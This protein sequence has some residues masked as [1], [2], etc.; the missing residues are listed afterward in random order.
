MVDRFGALPAPERLLEVARLRIA[1]ESAGIASLAREGHELIVRFSADWSRSAAMRAMAPTSI[2]DR[3]PHVAVG[4]IT[5]GSN[6]I[7]IRVSKEAATAWVTTRA[8]VER[9]AK[10]MERPAA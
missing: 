1:A 9:L 2:D 3:I 8:I 10:R 4:G 7:R 6:Q 5:Y